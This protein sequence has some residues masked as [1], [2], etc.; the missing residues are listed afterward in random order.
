MLGII[1]G[2][3]NG[4]FIEAR[5]IWCINELLMLMLEII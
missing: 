1:W 4:L 3:V 2:I 5:V